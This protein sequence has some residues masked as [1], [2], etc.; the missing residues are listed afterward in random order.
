MWGQL[1]LCCPEEDPLYLLKKKGKNQKIERIHIKEH[2]EPVLVPCIALWGRSPLCPLGARLAT[3]TAE[4]IYIFCFRN[5][6]SIR[7][8]EMKNTNKKNLALSWT[9]A[10]I[11]QLLTRF[12]CFLKPQFLY[13]M[14]YFVQGANYMRIDCLKQTGPTYIIS[15]HVDRMLSA[16]CSQYVAANA[17]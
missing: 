9:W 13:S 11:S 15:R 3:K 17:G 1:C 12:I 8:I 4:Q 2:I 14:C 16:S 6:V 10:H 7:N 5:N